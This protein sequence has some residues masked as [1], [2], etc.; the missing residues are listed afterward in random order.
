MIKLKDLLYIMDEDANI[1]IKSD[2][3]TVFTGDAEMAAYS[4][5]AN[6]TVIS[7]V[8]ENDTAVVWVKYR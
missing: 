7:I 1:I 3:K 8:L 2:L 6:Y 4:P 5:W